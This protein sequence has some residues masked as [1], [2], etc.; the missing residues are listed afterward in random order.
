MK[1]NKIIYWATT[2]IVSLMMLFSAFFYFSSP[3]AEENFRQLGFPGFFRIELG[4]A[5][6]IAAIILLLPQIPGVVKEW[7]YAGL[8][9]TFVSAAIAH[10]S[11]GD[12]AAMAA[13][14]L[15]VLAILIISNVYL[16]KTT[17]PQA[18]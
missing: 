15:I 3:E 6:I 7:A 14:P 13:T 2:G 16:K 11:N 9:I 5:K 8:G 1:K 12:P 17:V 4:V 18:H 10:V